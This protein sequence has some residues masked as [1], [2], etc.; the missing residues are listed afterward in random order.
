MFRRPLPDPGFARVVHAV[1]RA[2]QALTEAVPSP[3]GKVRTPLAEAVL[4]FE[5]ALREARSG[6]ESWH[7][8]EV[9]EAWR[10]CDAALVESLRRA[11][12]LRLAAP[13]LDYEGLVGALGELIAPLEAFADADRRFSR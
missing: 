5:E 10:A 13:D 6:M 11:E 8:S 7:R 2:K 3:R 12:G 1:E 4:A 9:E